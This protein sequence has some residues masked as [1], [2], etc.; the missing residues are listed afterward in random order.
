MAIPLRVLSDAMN[1]PVK[2]QFLPADDL[3]IDVISRR[4][5][6]GNMAIGSNLEEATATGTVT[7]S[8]V[9]AAGTTITIDGITLT[10]VA[11]PRTPGSDDFS[12]DSGTTAG[13]AAEIA[14]AINDG[15]NSFSGTV[16]AA[17]VGDD[18]NLTA[19]TAGSVGNSITLATSDD[20][21]YTLSGE[22][23]EGGSD[24]GELLLGTSVSDTR[25]LGDLI[26]DGSSIISVDETVIGNFSVEGSAD[27]GTGD[28]DVI[29]LGGGTGDTVNLN[30]DLVV[31]AGVVSAG[32]STSDYFGEI[33][34]EAVNDNTPD[35]DAYNLNASGTNAG[36]YAIGVNPSLLSSV[37]ATDLMSALIELDSAIS[38]VGSLQAAYEGGNTIDVSSAHSPLDFS[39]SNGADTTTVLSVSRNPG[40]VTGGDGVV[41]NLGANTTGNALRV[42]KAGTGDALQVNNTGSGNALEIQDSGSSV[43]RVTGSGQV[44]MT[45]TGGQDATVTVA[46]AGNVDV[47]SANNIELDATGGFISLDANGPSNFTTISG[48]LTLQASAG[49]LTFFDT[50]GAGLEFSQVGD[51]TLDKTA[52]G[53]V[54]ENATSLLGAL[55]ALARLVQEGGSLSAELPV[56][57]G[58]TISVGDVVSAS[59]VD[60]RVTQGSAGPAGNKAIIGI[61]LSGG[62]GDVGGTVSARFALSGSLVTVAGAS[63]TAGT[64]VFA[65]TTPGPPTDTFGPAV[66]RRNLRVGYAVSSTLM[67]FQ[68]VSGFIL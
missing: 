3:E 67:V 9:P 21:N 2:G 49:E 52:S 6:S 65:P 24:V 28:G 61:A 15:A 58:V 62:T 18:V 53:E 42:V 7:V 13:I 36:A 44:L 11:G 38:A 63:F 27:L 35:A 39:N 1:R 64:P 46:G 20:V 12:I 47:N 48:N 14:A 30:S 32:S 41:V 4:A 16:T 59:T 60:G 56:E 66:G 55:N 31:G 8:G 54:F 51:R 50:G 45:P 37:T 10:A 57:D 40:V 5:A 19:V 23:L 17:A 25:V 34:L 22:N 33:W 29:N 43:F 68:P 26:V